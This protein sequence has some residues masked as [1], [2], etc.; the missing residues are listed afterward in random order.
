MK[1][2]LFNQHPDCLLYMFRAFSEIGLEIE[3]A[4]ESLTL[5]LGFPHS[6]TKNNQFEVVNR[7]YKPEDFHP[8]FKNIKFTDIT[9][10]DIY[11]S[12]RPEVFSIFKEKA[13]FDAQMQDHIRYYGIFNCKKSCNHP[14]AKQFNFDFVS[15]WV[16]YSNNKLEKPYLITQLI[17]QFNE[18]E[19]TSELINLKKQGFNNIFIAGGDQCP[20]GFIRDKDI[21]TST[22]LLVHNKKFGINCYAVCKALDMGIPVYMSKHTK[23]LIGFDDLPDDLFHFKENISIL[24]AYK[25]SLDS[26]RKHIQDTYRSIYTLDRTVKT[27]KQCLAI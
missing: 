23:Q 7:L 25:L 10:H 18:V 6:S 3:F 17:T 12:I 14:D 19:E 11:L 1:I 4:T 22:S 27:L 5:S 24:D 8:L 15:N 20:D 21:L 13:Y 16:P 26:N 2:L 9:N